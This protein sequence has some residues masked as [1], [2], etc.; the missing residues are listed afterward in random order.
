V[1]MLAVVRLPALA[2]L[3]APPPRHS[4]GLAGHDLVD[5]HFFYPDLLI[6]RAPSVS[7]F[8]CIFFA[9]PLFSSYISYAFHVLCSGYC[10]GYNH[11]NS[12][13]CVRFSSLL[14]YCI[15][16][17]FLIIFVEGF[18]FVCPPQ[19]MYHVWKLRCYL[20]SVSYCICS[21][22]QMILD[23]HCSSD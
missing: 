20:C 12:R 16:V 23:K 10:V 18:G 22:R 1:W 3:A 2:E 13:Y 14:F 15:N 6:L 19:R 7:F 21:L 5:L 9:S 11:N 8:S 17:L 4:L